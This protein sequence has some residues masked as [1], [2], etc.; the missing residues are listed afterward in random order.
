ME[1]TFTLEEI[2]SVASGVLK[3][4]N[5]ER[6]IAFHGEMG[7]GKTTFIHALCDQMLVQ[8]VVGS[9]TFSLVNE[10]HSPTHGFI[11][12]IDLYRLN[13]I[14]EAVQAGI[15][16]CFY[17]G[18]MCLVEWPERVPALLPEDSL[19]LFLSVVSEATRLIRL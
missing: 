19:D 16:D 15:E 13:S 2:Q 14:E 7:A 9:P 4:W 5:G 3:H 10:Y 12:H 8:D 1:W 18:N 17:S 11:Y 6:V